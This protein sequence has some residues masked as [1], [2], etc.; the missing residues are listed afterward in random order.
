MQPFIIF[1]EVVA[2]KVT[3]IR[4]DLTHNKNIGFCL[5]GN[6]YSS[7]F[8]EVVAIKVSGIRQDLTHNKMLVSVC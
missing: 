5:V 6:C 8:L 2:I 1:L 4:Q 3:G 7:I